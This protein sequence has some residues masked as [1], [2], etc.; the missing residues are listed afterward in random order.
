LIAADR[1]E[2]K[3]KE[4]Y[5]MCKSIVLQIF[6]LTCKAGEY[7]NLTDNL[8]PPKIWR[9]WISIFRV[10]LPL[11]PEDEP[12]EVEQKDQQVPVDEETMKL[13]DECDFFEYKVKIKEI[14]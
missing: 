6:D 1:A 12:Q 14:Q 11:Y 2:A 8:I 9:D 10:G 13:L 4:H 3:Y 7:R 5:E